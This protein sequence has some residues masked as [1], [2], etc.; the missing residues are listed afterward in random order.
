MFGWGVSHVWQLDVRGVCVSMWAEGG[1]EWC[2]GSQE[3]CTIRVERRNA[4]VLRG[5]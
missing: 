5:R 4:Q 1:C 3:S 2:G